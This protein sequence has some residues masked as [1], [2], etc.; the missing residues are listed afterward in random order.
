LFENH[1]TPC[2]SEL[3]ENRIG[4]LFYFTEL[5]LF[6]YTSLFIF[7]M[8]Q[9]FILP[10]FYSCRIISDAII[11]T[12][13]FSKQL[14]IILAAIPDMEHG[15]AAY[16]KLKTLFDKMD[17]DKDIFI[18]SESENKLLIFELSRYIKVLFCASRK[19]C[20]LFSASVKDAKKCKLKN[21][22]YP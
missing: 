17:A 5:G 9:A 16:G 11:I 13:F 21:E 1:L 3:R 18:Y 19:K 6:T 8:T 7:L 4:F 22:G 14:W 10:Q 12:L 20:K 15:K 2:V